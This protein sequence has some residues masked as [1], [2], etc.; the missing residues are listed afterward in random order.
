M[1]KKHINMTL[2]EATISCIDRIANKSGLN[3]DGNR[4]LA[5]RHIVSE[6]KKHDSY[7]NVEEK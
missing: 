1:V 5:V 4:S 2:D 7:Y 3:Y 6:F